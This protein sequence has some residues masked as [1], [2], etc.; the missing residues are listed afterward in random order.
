MQSSIPG[1]LQNLYYSPLSFCWRSN[2][3]PNLSFCSFV[4]WLLS[5]SF[6]WN[7]KV[8]VRQTQKKIQNN[9]ARIVFKFPK[10]CHVS[11]LLRSLHWLPITK[12][13]FYWFSPLLFLVVNGTSQE[14]L[15]E[16]LTINTP[17]RQI[18]TTSDSRLCIIP[19]F[20]IKTNGHRFFF[21]FFFF[22]L[23]HYC[24]EQYSSNC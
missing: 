24:L 1:A 14:H 15:S 3:N 17:S 21:F 2:Q 10:H 7:L 23:R 6:S 16:L 12:R 20:K 5:L 13:M 22:I 9:A 8:S 19:S 18:R 4:N 11:P